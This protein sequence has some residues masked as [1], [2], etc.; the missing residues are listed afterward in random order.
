MLFFGAAK[1][2]KSHGSSQIWINISIIHSSL[3]FLFFPCN[4]PMLPPLLFL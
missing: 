4:L 2:R 3:L 1:T